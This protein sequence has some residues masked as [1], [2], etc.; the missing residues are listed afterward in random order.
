MTIVDL[1]D[2]REIRCIDDL[3]NGVEVSHW[4]NTHMVGGVLAILESLD[5]L[6]ASIVKMATVFA[7][8][9][10]LADLLASAC[11]RWSGSARFEA[12]RLFYAL[13][14]LVQ[15]QI[16][17]LDDDDI[18][19]LTDEERYA[20]NLLGPFKLTNVLVRKVAGAMVLEAQRKS[21][22]RQALMDRCLAKDLPERMDVIR[23]KKLIPHIPWYYQIELPQG[24]RQTRQYGTPNFKKGDN[25]VL[26]HRKMS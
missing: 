11:S 19:L 25:D 24:A 23:K 1:G 15:L 21:V 20:A 22:K 6:P 12:L 16:V 3:D 5:P 26:G 18:A 4:P 17:T 8:S 14:Q 7:G 9:F 10:N 2:E 13:N